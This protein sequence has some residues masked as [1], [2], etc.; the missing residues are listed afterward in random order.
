MCSSSAS[1]VPG[2]VHLPPARHARDESTSGKVWALG[3]DVS[4]R[5]PGQC[6]NCAVRLARFSRTSVCCP[7]SA[8][9]ENVAL[10]MVI[11]KLPSRHRDLRPR[12]PDL[13]ACRARNRACRTNSAVRNSA[14][15][16]PAPW[17]IAPKA[18]RL[19]DEPTGNLRPRDVA[20]HHAPARPN[21]T[22]MTAVMAT[23]D[24]T[25]QLTRMRKRASSNP[26]PATLSATRTVAPTGAGEVA[27]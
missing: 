24:A 25:G 20:G 13:V 4:K 1:R 18:S 23:H 26:R 3:K 17:R 14:W 7:P 21:R 15:P 10:A 2:N 9:Y 6:R 11:G 16:S 27:E 5:P 19:A 12:R 22:G 8:V